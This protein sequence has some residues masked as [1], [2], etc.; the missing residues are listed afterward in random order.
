MKVTIW[1]QRLRGEIRAI[2]S[3]SAAHRLLIC[4]ALAERPTEILCE[5]LSADIEATA[6]A[7]R[8]LGAEI[9]YEEPR[10]AFRVTPIRPAAGLLELESGETGQTD[11]ILPAAGL[12]GLDVGESGSTL[13]FLLPVICALGRET[14]IVMH[15]RLGERPLSPLWEELIRHG[16][17][18]T[19]NPDGTLG[20]RGKLRG[21]TFSLAANVSS[22]FISGL[23]FALPLMGEESRIR[24]EG[25]VESEGY[26]R[27]TMQALARFGVRMEWEGDTL[28][29]FGRLCSPGRAETEGDWSAGAFWEV[30]AMLSDGDAGGLTLTGL[31]PESAQG[32]RAV[33]WLKKEIAAGNAVIDARNI[34]DLVP[35]LAVLAAL[36]PGTTVFTGAGRLRLK[37]SDRIAST[38]RMLTDLVGLAE[39]T[40]D[41]LIVRGQTSL[42]G[43][44]VDSCG[45][46]RIA[47]SAAVASVAC[48]EKVEI[49]GAQAVRK[50]YPG[51]WEDF[52]RLGGRI[53]KEDA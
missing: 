3:K 28:R 7:L 11:P 42:R 15:G 20:T 47:M 53:Q 24:L 33:R 36:S 1:P 43:G 29:T 17:E 46:H 30:A 5:N 19:R 14:R 49:Y 23:L 6:D 4:G 13:R 41:G 31:G 34:P 44:T 22:Q 48:R 32:D 37:E 26:I 9:A 40:A 38:V 12:C 52:E 16:C 27:M 18:L 35:V 8:S 50:S 51:F 45:D 2:S 39:E 25:P 21:G 10:G